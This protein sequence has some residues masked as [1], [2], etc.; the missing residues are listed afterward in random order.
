[1]VPSSKNGGFSPLPQ[2]LPKEPT[3]LRKE[4]G[5]WLRF[6]H[7]EE[8]QIFRAWGEEARGE[9]CAASA[10]PDPSD[11]FLRIDVTGL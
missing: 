8:Q 5:H 6:R 1:M 3:H 2:Q 4:S 11:V 10:R 9:Q 7:L